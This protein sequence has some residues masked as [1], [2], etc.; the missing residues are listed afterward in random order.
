MKK[1]LISLVIGLLIILAVVAV[2]V[3][4]YIGPIIKTGIETF[5]PKITQVP[6]KLDAVDVSLLGGAAAIK[7]LVVGNPEGFSSPEAIKLGK[8]EVNLDLMSVTSPKIKIRKIHVVSPEITLDGGL[9]GNNLTKIMDNVNKAAP[10][11]ASSSKPEASAG[12]SQGQAKPAPKIQV[13]DFLITGA[14]VHVHLTG[15]SSKELTVPLPEIHLT[16]LGQSDEGITPAELVQVV[17]SRVNVETLKAAG[18]AIT[19]SGQLIEGLGKDVAG[20]AGGKIKSVTKS[21]EGIFGK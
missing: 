5:G 1:I 21:I 14:K 10:Q 2:G 8:A 3:G 11:E 12:K 19:S 17:L 9:R 16:N 7:G 4:L 6:I 15:L 20:E 18:E 13:D